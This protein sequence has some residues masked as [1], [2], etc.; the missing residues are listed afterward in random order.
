[1]FF[2]INFFFP[3]FY[4]LE[5][6][7]I[8]QEKD[9]VS[10]FLRSKTSSFNDSLQN[11]F[12]YFSIPIQK[13]YWV[14]ISHSEKNKYSMDLPRIN[15]A[16]TVPLKKKIRKM[17]S[18]SF[19]STSGRLHN[20]FLLFVLSIHSLTSKYWKPLGLQVFDLVFAVVVVVVYRRCH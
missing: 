17:S 20:S 10:F 1:M 2:S 5:T 12:N 14:F 19:R 6:I 4:Y 18:L 9:S 16:F 8:S 3:L 11:I 7:I 13:M 15:S